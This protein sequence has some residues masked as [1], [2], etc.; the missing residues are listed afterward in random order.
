MTLNNIGLIF[1]KMR[2]YDEALRLAH[3]AIALGGRQPL[4]REQLVAAGQWKE[5]P[6]APAASA[7][8]PADAVPASLAASAT[9]VPAQGC[10]VSCSRS[11]DLTSSGC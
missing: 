3:R 10:R 11:L 1:A 6:P 7:A 2:N 4:L 9:S 5:P 8:S